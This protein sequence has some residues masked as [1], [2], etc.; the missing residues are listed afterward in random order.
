MMKKNKEKTDFK[1]NFGFFELLKNN[2][3]INSLLS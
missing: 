3:S 2:L 1:N